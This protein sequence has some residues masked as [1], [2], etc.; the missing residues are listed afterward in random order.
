M[1][2]FRIGEVA[3]L[4]GV[5]PDTVRRWVDAGRLPA[6]RDEQGRRLVDGADLA[7]FMREGADDDPARAFSSARNRFHGLVT[8]ITRDGVMAQV[9]MQAGVHRVVSLLSREAVDE[10]GLEVGSLAVA[11]VKSTNVVVETGAGQGVRHA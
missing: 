8:A 1:P 6:D 3:E 10:M 5:S 2:V 11:V 9:E 4:V 7:A